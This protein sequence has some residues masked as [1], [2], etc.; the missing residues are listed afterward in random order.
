MK[1]RYIVT[2][3]EVTHEQVEALRKKSHRTYYDCRTKL[4][5]EVRILQEYVPHPFENDPTNDDGMPCVGIW[6]NVEP[7]DVILLRGQK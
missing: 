3:N 6:R 7:P 1:L 4:L 5:D 2:R